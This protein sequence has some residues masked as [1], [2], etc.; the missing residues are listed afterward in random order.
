M[1][2]RETVTLDDA[3][4]LGAFQADPYIKRERVRSVLCVPILRQAEVLG[5]LY[6]ENNL[7]SHAFTKERLAIL[8]VI[9]SQAAISIYNAQLYERLEQRVAQ[10][11]EELAFKN[12]QVASMLDNMDQGVFTIDET[13]SVQPEYSRYLEQILGT[14]EIVGKN[15]IEL[16]FKVRTCAPTRWSRARLPCSSASASR[17]GWRRPMRRT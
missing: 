3:G 8:Q 16:L 4:V 6:L 1:R 11:T 7:T 2:S 5:V 14:T 9:A 17:L 15:C 13:L 10:R 12:R